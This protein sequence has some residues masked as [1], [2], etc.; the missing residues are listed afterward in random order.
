MEGTTREWVAFM[1][2][3]YPRGDKSDNGAVYR[4]SVAVAYLKSV[5]ND[6]E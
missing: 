3:Y 6:A 4:P 2:K 1:D 5:L